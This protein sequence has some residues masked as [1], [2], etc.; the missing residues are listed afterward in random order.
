MSRTI[1]GRYREAVLGS[2]FGQ[3][4]IVR[5]RVSGP[6]TRSNHAFMRATWLPGQNQRPHDGH[7]L[8]GQPERVIR[9]GT[10]PIASNDERE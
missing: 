2:G 5:S 7:Q 4:R 3:P 6:S 8:S 1:D 10:S 9:A